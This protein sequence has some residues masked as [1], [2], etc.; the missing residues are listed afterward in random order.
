MN[1]CNKIRVISEK[2]CNK[3]RVT[4]TEYEDLNKKAS[5]QMEK[6]SDIRKHIDGYCKEERSIKPENFYKHFYV[7]K[8]YLEV[9]VLSPEQLKLLTMAPSWKK[10]LRLQKKG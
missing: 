1:F 7:R 4:K 5:L 2:D 10:K 8:E 9:L 3:I 6:I